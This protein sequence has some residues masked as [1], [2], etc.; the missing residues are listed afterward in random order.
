M[1]CVGQVSLKTY[2]YTDKVLLIDGLKHNLLSISQLCDSGNNVIF[3]KGKYIVYQH[4]GTKM[5]GTNRQGNLYKINMDE[6]S[7]QRVSCL[8]Y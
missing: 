7:D 4:D 5:F 2:L 1:I 6:L 3:D 8:M